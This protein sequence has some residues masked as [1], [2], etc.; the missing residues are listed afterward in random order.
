MAKAES[1]STSPIYSILAGTG[2][3]VRKVPAGTPGARTRQY[4]DRETKNMVTKHE[5]VAS[6]VTGKIT[7]INLDEGDYGM[8]LIVGLDEDTNDAIRVAMG[9]SRTNDQ[10]AV[11]FMKKL[12]NIDLM[13]E[14]TLSPFRGEKSRVIFISQ[15]EDKILDAYTKYDEEAKKW[16]YLDIGMPQADNRRGTKEYWTDEYFPAVRKFLV[17][18]TEKSAVFGVKHAATQNTVSDAPEATDEVPF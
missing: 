2:E 6:R 12:P 14:V 10:Y 5:I 18:E 15:G 13:K 4:E 3:L 11:D 16:V 17:E 8:Q 7:S 9:C 1:F